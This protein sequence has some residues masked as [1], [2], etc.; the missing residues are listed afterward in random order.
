MIKAK[1]K[2]TNEEILV[3]Q[4]GDAYVQD[5]PD[6]DYKIYIAEDLEFPD[7]FDWKQIRIQFI[8][9]ALTGIL[10]NYDTTLK[11]ESIV[12]AAIKIADATIAE[13]KK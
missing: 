8:S 2:N 5:L 10:A 7:E 13:L 9:A 3:T 4:Y 6:G 1:I 11:H 12:E